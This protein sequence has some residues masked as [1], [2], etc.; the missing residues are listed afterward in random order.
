M[1]DNTKEDK[2]LDYDDFA[3]KLSVR[4]QQ[5][6]LQANLSQRD[7]ANKIGV[8]KTYISNIERGKTKMPAFIMNAYCHILHISPDTI[9]DYR[10]GDS[11]IETDILK[12]LEHLTM[13]QKKII[14]TMVKAL[15]TEQ[16]AK[17]QIKNDSFKQQR[18]VDKG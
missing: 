13:E 14:R 5:Y 17:R 1:I 3:L 15:E 8:S 9:T 18:T 7:M 2:F 12:S 6:R 4:A 11:D 10:Y 16:I